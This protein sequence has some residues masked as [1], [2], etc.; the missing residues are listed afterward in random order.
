MCGI[1]GYIGAKGSAQFVYNGLKRLEYRGY[2]SAGIV[3]LADGKIFMEKEVGK[4]ES[5]E[6]YLAKL[7]ENANIGLGHTRWATHGAPNKT[8]AHPHLVGGVA[9]VHNGIIENHAEFRQGIAAKGSTFNSETDSEVIAHLFSDH[10]KQGMTP[11]DA[12]VKTVQLLK[13]SYSIGAVVENDPHLYLAKSGAPMVIGYSDDEMM[14]SSDVTTFYGKPIKA[15][16]LND[17]ECAKIGLGKVDVWKFD[18][19]PAPIEPIK[20]VWD[21]SGN[22]EKQGFRHFMLKEIYEQPSML[23]K[24]ARRFLDFP[25]LTFNENELALTKLSLND[26]KSV[27]IIAC[28]TAYLAGAIGRYFI[29]PM[30]GIPVNV[31]IASEF[32]YRKPYIN[33][34]TLVIG[35]SQSGETADTLASLQYAKAQGCQVLAIC[36]SQFSSISRMATST[37]HMNAGPEIGVAST[38][39]FTSQVLC[40]YMWTLAVAKRAKKIT[41]ADLQKV[42]EDLVKLTPL[43]ELVLGKEKSI[44]ELALK[45]YES[46]NFIYIGRGPFFPLAL[47]GALK[48]KEIS[49]IHAEGYASGELKHGPI[50]L[51]DGHM[52]TVALALKNSFYEKTISNIEEVL[53][54]RG[55]VVAVAQDNDETLKSICHDVITVPYLENEYL[56]TILASV[57]LQLFAYHIAV[58]RGT[59]VDQPRNL[60]KSVTVE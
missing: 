52:P 27:H 33:K 10:L 14:F 7:P 19:K 53:A 35:I 12:L 34:N 42:V 47:E 21:G 13:G 54:R 55:K 49:Y 57:P 45:Y 44:E 60:A 29:E 37:L 36:N 22:P 11:Q 39:A 15:I 9:I 56:Q 41:E 59:D 51:I 32:R 8:N 20:M 18:G 24:T 6:P 50:A 26:I 46:P 1:F 40:L 4:L 5:L 31:E 30:L 17:G 58:A 23:G 2:D 28:G 38:K 43:M 16:F 25:T 48:L 3:V